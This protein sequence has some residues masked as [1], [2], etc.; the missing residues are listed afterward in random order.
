MLVGGEVEFLKTK[1]I[2]QKH[3]IEPKYQ[4]AK[5]TTCGLAGGEINHKGHLWIGLV[6]TEHGVGRQG[7]LNSKVWKLGITLPNR[8][9]YHNQVALT[10]CDVGQGL[11][12]AKKTG[13]N[14]LLSN[15][16]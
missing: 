11:E 3:S 9:H 7:D 10:R 15:W 13:I 5:S 1:D 4:N 12:D 6:L 8:L 2:C 16:G 14:R